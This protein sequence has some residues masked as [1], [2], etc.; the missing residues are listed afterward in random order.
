MALE[1]EGV[2]RKLQGAPPCCPPQCCARCWNPVGWDLGLAWQ[3]ALGVTWERGVGAC[4]APA[5]EV[6]ER[7][8]SPPTPASNARLLSGLQQFANAPPAPTPTRRRSSRGEDSCLPYTETPGASA[9]LTEDMEGTTAVAGL[10]HRGEWP[11]LAGRD[12]GAAEAEGTPPALT[13][14]LGN[15]GLLFHPQAQR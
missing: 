10:A 1:K 13:W 3:G 2:V 14:L 6:E 11:P 4:L 7:R 5:W 15:L 12:A 9:M 8:T